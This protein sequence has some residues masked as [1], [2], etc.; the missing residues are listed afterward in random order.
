MSKDPYLSQAGKNL[1]KLTRKR[2][3]TN[4]NMMVAIFSSFTDWMELDAKDTPYAIPSNVNPPAAMFCP[5]TPTCLEA[6]IQAIIAIESPACQ[7][8]ICG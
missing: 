8:I 1:Q 3:G 4:G 6:K 7:Q 2:A 5:L